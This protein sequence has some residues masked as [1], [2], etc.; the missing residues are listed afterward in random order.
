MN[1]NPRLMLSVLAVVVVLAAA[2]VL[3]WRPATALSTVSG[4]G[5][6]GRRDRAGEAAPAPAEPVPGGPGF[7]SLHAAAFR[8]YGATMSWAFYDDELYNPGGTDSDLQAEVSLPNG[9]TITKFVVYY[10]DDCS[11]HDMAVRLERSAASSDVKQPIAE[12]TTSGNEFSYR[13][14]EDS[15]ID[16]PVVDQQSYA[17]RVIVLLPQ[18][19][20]AYLTLESVRIDY[21]YGVSLPIAARGQ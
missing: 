7:Y 21:G 2:P 12:T 18:G 4:D 15:T 10:F 13:Y 8:P 16:L 14:A 17:Y 11:S 19:C 3:F 1:H 9:A 20:D 5:R 6:G